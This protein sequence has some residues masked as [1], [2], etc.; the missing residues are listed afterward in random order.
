MIDPELLMNISNDP[1]TMQYAHRINANFW[2]E[3][4]ES[5]VQRFNVWAS[6]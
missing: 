2:V 3:Y 6:Q 5:L 4:G 1:D